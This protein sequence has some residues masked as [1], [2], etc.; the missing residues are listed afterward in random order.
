MQQI[1][2]DTLLM[3][4]KLEKWLRCCCLHSSFLLIRCKVMLSQTSDVYVWRFQSV[5]VGR[6]ASVL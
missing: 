5:C 6:E 2:F 4:Q 1:V 3:T